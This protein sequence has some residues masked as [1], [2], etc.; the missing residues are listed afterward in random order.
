[1]AD[2]AHDTGEIPAGHEIPG[3]VRKLPGIGIH[4]SGIEDSTTLPPLGLGWEGS[5]VLAAL[6]AAE[7]TMPTDNPMFSDLADLSVSMI[8][9]VLNTRAQSASRKL[10]Q[11]L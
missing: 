3:V 1:M 7:H 9:H 6:E 2:A 4:A 5:D 10:L 8:P 11:S